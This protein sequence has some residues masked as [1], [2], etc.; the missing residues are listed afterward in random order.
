[1]ANLIC[2]QRVADFDAW[3][4]VFQSHAAA[5]RSAGLEIDKILRNIDDPSEVYMVFRV[6]ELDKAREFVTSSDVTDAQRESGVVSQTE[7]LF[8]E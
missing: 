2:R 3:K 8:L 7:I 1:V 4:R 5:Q 6:T